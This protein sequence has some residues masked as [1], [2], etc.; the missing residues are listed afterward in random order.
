MLGSNV[1][2][3][4]KDNVIDGRKRE[5]VPV[6]EMKYDLDSDELS[7]RDCSALMVVVR[8]DDSDE[9]G[10]RLLVPEPE[11]VGERDNVRDPL[12]N[13]VAL[14]VGD[15]EGS[16]LAELDLRWVGLSVCDPESV[17]VVEGVCVVVLT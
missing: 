10:L 4:V 9:D 17:F 12:R 14:S 5:R 8:D 7:E 11:N 15:A 6:V 1:T 3:V 16:Q 2:A 13:G